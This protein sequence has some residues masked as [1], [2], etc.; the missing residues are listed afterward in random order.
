MNS[1]RKKRTI[2][3]YEFIQQKTNG[4]L[5][6]ELGKGAFGMVRLAKDKISGQ[7]VAI[8]TVHLNIIQLR[9]LRKS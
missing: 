5:Q 6:D 4:K 9:S 1:T 7:K 2:D 8:K 3:D